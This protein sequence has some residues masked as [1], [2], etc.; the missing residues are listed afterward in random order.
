MF[1][2]SSR[3]QQH[4]DNLRSFLD[5]LP[6]PFGWRFETREE[7]EEVTEG[8][9]KLNEKGYKTCMEIA[10]REKAAGNKAFAANNRKAAL[11]AY[12]KAI[13][14]LC[15][16]ARQALSLEEEK[17]VDRMIAICYS[18]RAATHMMPGVELDAQ[19][20]LDDGQVAEKADPS[21]NKWFVGYPTVLSCD[22]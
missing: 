4:K 10:E 6:K 20:A 2:I 13:D 8:V 18:N 7:A 14:A 5:S 16:A 9:W 15:D 1:M 22:Y 21:Y 3:L 17:R 19:K 11:E 12:E